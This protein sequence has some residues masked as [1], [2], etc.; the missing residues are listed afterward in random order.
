[1][2]AIESGNT[3]KTFFI[4]LIL[5]FISYVSF[6]ILALNDPIVVQHGFRQTH[7]ALGS[8]YLLRD[9][10]SFAYEIP[11]YG[12]PW[13]V[14]HEF[15]IY[16]WIVAQLS[17]AFN[18]PLTFTG[19][20]VSLIYGLLIA[21][22]VFNILK[23]L[24][25]NQEAIYLCFILIFSAPVF[26]YWSS[27]FMI[28]TS[29]LLYTLCFIY[30][31]VKIIFGNRDLLSLILLSFFLTLALLQ[32]IT[33]SFPILLIIS[34]IL[35]IY[36]LKNNRFIKEY[37]FTIKLAISF[38]IP[39]CIFLSWFLF[40]EEVK[41][42]NPVMN[43]LNF[44]QSIH[45]YFGTLKDRISD[46]LWLK[47]VFERNVIPSSGI[48]IGFISF[49]FFLSKNKDKQLKKVILILL[50]FFLAPF[51][52]HTKVHNAHKYY[53]VANFIYW[54][55]ISG[56][57]IHFFF[58]EYLKV[59]V[60]KFLFLVCILFISNSAF[61]LH[62]YFFHF[63]SQ[64]Q[65][66]NKRTILLGEYI[67][68]ST[69]PDTPIVIFGYGGSS[70]LTFYSKRKALSVVNDKQAI[71]ILNNIDKY[72][73]KTPSAFILCPGMSSR[74]KILHDAYNIKMTKKLI[75]NNFNTHINQQLVLDCE[76]I[77]K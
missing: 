49:L 7:N 26:M 61:F 32:K 76:V 39:C 28:E 27:T 5:T 65:E 62:K 18:F 60:K 15:P 74:G 23:V 51:L 40:S 69:D 21:I 37:K 50:A 11:N 10:F 43:H 75:L 42:L 6:N 48:F 20:L 46:S 30:Y 25:I 9:G 66:H 63:K 56:I 64:I 22:P 57:S 33:T 55:I 59:N 8:Y 34:I 14:P 44:E 54:S 41:S 45:W 77:S 4:L 72:L 24:K 13:S 35:L 67:Q 19:R 70:V 1:M 53:Q 68:S 47:N 29:A 73:T 12:E 3:Q 2:V 71:E 17:N 38:I 58:R 16:Q 31:A 36:L 52:I